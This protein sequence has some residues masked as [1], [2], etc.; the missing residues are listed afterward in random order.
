MFPVDRFLLLEVKYKDVVTRFSSFRRI[1]TRMLLALALRPI[2]AQE[3]HTFEGIFRQL[4]FSSDGRFALAQDELEISVMSVDPLKVLFRIPAAIATDV[5]FTPD[6]MDVVFVSSPTRVD[7]LQIHL[8]KDPARVE[9]WSVDKHALVASSVL[10]PLVCGTQ[11]LSPDGGVFACLD[12]KGTLWFINV[13]SGET[14]LEKKAYTALFQNYTKYSGV[15]VSYSGDL[16]AAY[17]EFSPDGHFVMVQPQNAE[18]KF[19]T[20]NLREKTGVRLGGALRQLEMHGPQFIGTDRIML[21]DRTTKDGLK[22]G[23]APV[24]ILTFPGGKLI[25]RT[26]IPYGNSY[27]SADPNWVSIRPFGRYYFG[28]SDSKRAAVAQLSTGVVVISETPALDV[29]GTRYIVEHTRGEV[30][31]YEVGH[32]LKASVVISAK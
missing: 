23:V 2:A 16:G 19:L 10:P 24:R 22:Q 32:G 7:S 14:I 25:S 17:M 4:R 13:I 21:G 5:Q 30:G 12:L 1:V 29:F 8:A 28:H 3:S 15:A 26:K 9:R 6:S 20:W 11:M 18:G 31:L 27:R